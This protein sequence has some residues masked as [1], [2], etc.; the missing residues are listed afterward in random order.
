MNFLQNIHNLRQLFK[1]DREYV[2]FIPKDNAPYAPAVSTNYSEVFDLTPFTD[3]T[4]VISAGSGS[5]SISVEAESHGGNWAQM[6]STSLRGIRL[7]PIVVGACRVAV[8]DTIT[9]FVGLTVYG[10]VR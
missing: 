8:P 10:R 1:S 5:G 2:F 6:F 4:L 7:S 3:V 9:N